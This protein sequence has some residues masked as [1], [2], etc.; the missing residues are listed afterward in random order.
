MRLGRAADHSPPS[1]AAGVGEQSYTST[2]LLGPN[3][4]VTG[5]LYLYLFNDTYYGVIEMMN[6]NTFHF[7]S[8]MWVMVTCT[9]T[10]VNAAGFT[11]PIYV[12][13]CT[14]VQVRRYTV[15]LSN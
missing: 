13:N 4:P 15:V 1:N 7:V 11:V 14:A 5:L 2:H 3:G 10:V 6:V 12:C 9:E 8:V